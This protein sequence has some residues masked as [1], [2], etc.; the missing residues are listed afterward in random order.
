MVKIRERKRAIVKS[1]R[2]GNERGLKETDCDAIRYG[3]GIVR[4]TEIGA[5]GLQ[6]RRRAHFAGGLNLYQTLGLRSAVP[7]IEGLANVPYLDNRSVME[8]GKVPNHLI[9]L[10]GGY[11]GLEFGQ[12]FRRLGSAVT[13]VQSG[14]KLLTRED[15]D[16]ADEVA[17]DPGGG[18]HQ[19]AFECLCSRVFGKKTA[20]VI[21][22]DCEPWDANAL[23]SG[24]QPVAGG[25]T[26]A[27]IP[28]G[29]I[30]RRPG[31]NATSAVTF[32]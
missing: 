8:L 5:R 25:W 6:R 12:L 23:V 27:E 29:S 15:D 9:V 2:E 24:S 21:C 31:L 26:D 17:K 19:G 32:A 16:V 10:G 20:E 30:P 4:R 14:A 18:R 1:F 28:R 13:I 3:R 7:K 22:N 11:I